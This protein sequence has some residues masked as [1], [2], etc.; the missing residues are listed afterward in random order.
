VPSGAPL[1]PDCTGQELTPKCYLA[2]MVTD[3]VVQA[4]GGTANAKGGAVVAA[5][6]WRAGNKQ[7]IG[8]YVESP[9]NGIYTSATGAPGSFAKVDPTT[10]LFASGPPNGGTFQDTIGRVELGA[11]TGAKQDHGYL[12]AIV[13]DATAFKSGEVSGIDVP[14]Q[15]PATP[16]N[17]YLRGVYVSRDFGQ[18][19][20]LMTNA[21]GLQDPTT[22]SALT[23]TACATLY[24]PGVQAWY[25]AWIQPDP[26]QQD[27]SGA[28]TR[29][30]FGLE[31]I[32]QNDE[33]GGQRAPAT[34]P[35]KFKVIGRY[36]GGTTCA[37]LTN[38]L[39]TCPTNRGDANSTTTHPDQHDGLYVPRDAGGVTL[40]AGNDGGAYQQTL[41][42]GQEF[43]NTAWGRGANQG[44]HTLLPYD[45]QVANDGTI[46][47]G[48]Q[49]NGE[50]KIQPDGTQI[51]TYGG[52]GFYTAVNP[53]D[54]NIAYEE[55]A[56]ASPLNVTTDGGKTWTDISP[57]A[58]SYQFANPF[59]MDPGDPNHLLTGGNNVVETTAGPGTQAADWKQVFTLG[60]SA[61]GVDF[62]NSAVDVRSIGT[63]ATKGLP[64]G[65]KTADVSGKGGTGTIP[66]GGTGAPQTYDE[67]PFTI[68]PADGDASVTVSVKWAN[69]QDDYDLTLYHE[70]DG[71]QVAVATSANGNTTQEQVVVPDPKPGKYT[72]HVDNFAATG[73]YDWAAT[74]AQR[75]ADPPAATSAAY[76]A[77]C[78]PCDVLNTRPFANVLATNVTG[79][80]GGVAGSPDGWHI[81]KAQGLP[82]R[83]ITSVQVDQT[84]PAVVYATLAGYSRRWLPVG[85]LGEDTS[86][87]GTGHV[88]KST[89]GGETFKDVSGNLPDVPANFVIVRNGRLIVA[90]DLGVFESQNTDG[91][92]YS[93]LGTGLPA[94]PVL[95]LELKADD[96]D[97]LVVATQGRGVYR[98]SFKPRAVGAGGSGSST[99][100][101][102][103]LAVSQGGGSCLA[104]KA[105]KRASARPARGNRRQVRLTLPHTKRGLTV[106]VFQDS[107]GRRIYRDRLV[108][109]FTGRKGSFTWN[110][111]SN[112][113][114]RAVTDGYYFVRIRGRGGLAGDGLL[115]RTVMHRAGGK[116]RLRPDHYLVGRCGILRFFKL[117]SPVWGGTR[118]RS[119]GIAYRTS[120]K[121]RVNVLVYRGKKLVRAFRG[122]QARANHTYRLSVTTKGKRRGDYRVVLSGVAGKNRVVV[123]LVSRKI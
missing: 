76:V 62:V 74:F 66:G 109:R 103:G 31:E 32:W 107:H 69:A 30:T 18:T 98:Y 68:G 1:T 114:G 37:F 47:A 99:V 48:L 25:N 15:G 90:N 21:T 110:G 73:G 59:V 55:Y 45:A 113:R 81:A 61:A 58:D 3:V 77:G 54:A 22:G 46:W 52:D 44:F 13:Q 121:A 67:H 82:N 96:P 29:L 12:Y 104:G 84:N 63:G 101:G 38:P 92:T 94:A 64:T 35:T 102:T 93:V 27:A 2:N 8:G 4:P 6:G 112:R 9:N 95:S 122:R 91:G 80:K 65:P 120:S 71:K 79:G 75:A 72:I 23:G 33:V 34:G 26:T 50:M 17:T 41:K 83:Y 88:F 10:S 11:A 115:A 19:W 85:V 49:D 78:G 56:L 60:Q 86:K 100:T 53:Q 57:P 97:T 106:E 39:P 14:E 119:L 70:E 36:F 20:V 40:F 5:V 87:A 117:E 24:C 28:P 123:R 118:N 43:Q 105:S 111:R 89:D 16:S 42:A 116:W 7:N 108:A 51:A